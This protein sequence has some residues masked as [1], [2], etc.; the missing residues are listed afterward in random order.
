MILQ[1]ETEAPPLKKRE[2]SRSN[3][4]EERE[5]E[6]KHKRERGRPSQAQERERE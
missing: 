5:I 4:R 3:I 6:A 1:K 2:W